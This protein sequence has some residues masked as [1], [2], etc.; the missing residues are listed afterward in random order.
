MV[1]ILIIGVILLIVE[2]AIISEVYDSGYGAGYCEGVVDREKE[3]KDGE[4]GEN[5]A[6]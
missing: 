6:V 5:N 3:K 1:K 4:K 2:A